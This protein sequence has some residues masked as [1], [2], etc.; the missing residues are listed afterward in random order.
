MTYNAATLDNRL[1]NDVCSHCLNGEALIGDTNDKKTPIGL[2]YL[3][4]LV[5]G[6]AV[7]M[8]TE[9]SHFAYASDWI[10]RMNGI[11]F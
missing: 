6:K 2:F 10:Q 7:S 4:L 1:G 5:V 8:S 3:S 9:A 11:G